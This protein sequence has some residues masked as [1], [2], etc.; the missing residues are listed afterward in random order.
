VFTSLIEFE[1][2]PAAFD[3]YPYFST[4]MYS[5]LLQASQIKEHLELGSLKETRGLL[6]LYYDKLLFFELHQV[7]LH[8]GERK[9]AALKAGIAFC[10]QKT[11]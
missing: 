4:S 11:A 1:E 6:N 8:P 3:G 2:K 7:H 5:K 10:A 9:L